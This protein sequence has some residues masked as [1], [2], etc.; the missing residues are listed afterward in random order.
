MEPGTWSSP[1]RVAIA[2]QAT[3]FP[4]PSSAAGFHRPAAAGFRDQSVA[5]ALL[6]SGFRSAHPAPAAAAGLWAT[7]ARARGAASSPVTTVAV[8]GRPRGVDLAS[9]L[10]KQGPIRRGLPSGQDGR[11]L[12]LSIIFGGYGSL[13]SQGRH[14]EEAAERISAAPAPSRPGGLRNARPARPWRTRRH[15]P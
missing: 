11:R 10:R 15:R 3:A 4:S 5:R 2:V 7:T 8:L 1:P 14:T 9:S 13:L 6:R 12:S